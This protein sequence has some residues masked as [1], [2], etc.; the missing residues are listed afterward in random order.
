MMAQ[1]QAMEEELRRANEHIDKNFDEL[2]RRGVLGCSLADELAAALSQIAGLR[3]ELQGLQTRQQRAMDQL[4]E[5]RCPECDFVF[6]ATRPF[7]ETMIGSSPKT[8]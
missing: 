7:R 8:L 6:D 3:G 4:V 2:E 5:T 1:L